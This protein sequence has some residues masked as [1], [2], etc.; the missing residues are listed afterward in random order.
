MTQ[1][2]EVQRRINAFSTK[3]LQ[4]AAQMEELGRRMESASEMFRYSDFAARFADITDRLHQIQAK[5]ISRSE[6]LPP[7][8]VAILRDEERDAD[9]YLEALRKALEILNQPKEAA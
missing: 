8:L 3:M 5:A 4:A 9:V 7:D 1:F 2:E 6:E